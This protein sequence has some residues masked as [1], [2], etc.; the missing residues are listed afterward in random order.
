[1]LHAAR[2]YSQMQ[3]VIVPSTQHSQLDAGLY[4]YGV[5]CHGCVFTAVRGGYRGILVTCTTCGM[6][7]SADCYYF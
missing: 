1:M 7:H 3:L 6:R 5:Q 4:A 2:P